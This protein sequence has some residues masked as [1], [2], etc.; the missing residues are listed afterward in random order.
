MEAAACLGA[1]ARA[2]HI[3]IFAVPRP[4]KTAKLPK[5]RTCAPIPR[6]HDPHAQRI[7]DGVAPDSPNYFCRIC[8]KKD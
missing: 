7:P 1:A 6:A 3:H 8:Q 2:M 5:T 4:S